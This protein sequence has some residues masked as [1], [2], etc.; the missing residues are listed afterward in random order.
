MTFLTAATGRHPHGDF[1]NDT[2]IGGVGNDILTGS[3][4]AYNDTID[5]RAAASGI[6]V[7]LASGTASDDGD[8]GADTL[9]GI[10]SVIGSAY[11]DTIT[12]TS[13]TNISAVINGGAATTQSTLARQFRRRRF[14]HWRQRD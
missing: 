9:S 7:S 4:G 5:Y 11:A 2:L 3:S 8:G 6:T 13:T 10:E 14:N 1:G 12:W